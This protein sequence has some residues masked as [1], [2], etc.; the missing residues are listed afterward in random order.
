V[1]G[2]EVGALAEERDGVRR[3]ERRHLVVDLATNTQQ[4]TTGDQEI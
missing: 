2:Q 4:L 1:I 3:G